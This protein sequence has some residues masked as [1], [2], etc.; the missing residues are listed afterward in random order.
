MESA[1]FV[2]G[3]FD[4]NQLE[5]VGIPNHIAE[6]QISIVLEQLLDDLKLNLEQNGLSTFDLMAKSFAKSM[7]IKNGVSLKSEEMTNMVD[8]L[9]ACKEPELAPNGKRSY[10]LLDVN[11]LE[12]LLN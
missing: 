10:V 6:S 12:K 1:G 8:Q 9:F 3:N 2:F 7:A 11:V 5:V 4:D